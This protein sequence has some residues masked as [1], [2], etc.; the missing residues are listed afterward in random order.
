MIRL[1]SHLALLFSA[2]LAIPLA[3]EAKF[4]PVPWVQDASIYEVNIRQYSKEGTFR[5]F[6][7]A[8]PR[9]KKMGVKVLWIMPIQPIGVKERK[10]GL[11]SYYSIKDYKGINAEFGDLADFK[12]LVTRAQSMGFK[13]ILDWVANHT[14]R[15]HPWVVAH[16]DWYQKNAKGEIGGYIFPGSDGTESW[17]DV[18]GLDYSNPNVRSS[19]VDAME[20]WVRETGIDGFR[21]DVAG[22]VP[23]DFWIDTRNKLDQIKPLLWLA[24]WNDPEIHKAFDLS[25]HWELSNLFQEI[26][27]GKAS[28]ETLRDLYRKGD[29]R[30][31]GAIR[32]NFTSNHDYNSWHGTDRELYGPYAEVFSVL[33]MTLPGVPLI[34]SGQEAGLDKR[35]AFFEKDAISWDV[36]KLKDR[37][38][39]Y[40]NL[41]QMRPRPDAAFA[42][43]ETGNS[44]VFAFRRG[45]KAKGISVFANLSNTPQTI[46]GQAKPVAPYGWTIIR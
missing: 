13:V 9:L 4:T 23:I 35:I 8:L 33:A 40:R 30:F 18:S 34:Y 21:C 44:N 12:H 22:L 17:S 26:K 46:F 39:F 16:P 27:K 32:M 25:Y 10:G 11:G 19:M 14:A 5:A 2:L 6:A 1:F 41:L 29:A 31:A 15:D 37:S 3:A 7:S 43:I 20:F 24:E 28:A 36:A 38:A 42:I 45:T